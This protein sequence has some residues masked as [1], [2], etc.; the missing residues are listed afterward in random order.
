MFRQLRLLWAV[1]L[2]VL[3]VSVGVAAAAQPPASANLGG[4]GAARPSK[5]TVGSNTSFW[6]FVR[7]FGPSPATGVILSDALPAGV[8]FVSALPDQGSCTGT[9]TVLCSLGS[10]AVNQRVR[11][12]ITVKATAAGSLT[13]QVSVTANEHDPSLSNN[14]FNQPLT[15]LATTA[16]PPPV[17]V[18]NLAHCKRGCK[19]HLTIT[20]FFA[21]NSTT[22]AGS[23]D[24]TVAGTTHGG[25]VVPA[26]VVASQVKNGQTVG[27]LG[28]EPGSYTI[29]EQGTVLTNATSTVLCSGETTPSSLPHTITITKHANVTCTIINT[30]H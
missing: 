30:L 26:T 6:L 16:A 9:T 28:V 11:V 14:S 29:S 20:T 22:P 4:F 23:I 12:L 18:G 27:P 25:L 1:V 21:P 7:D 2:G 10:L 13:N 17:H 3:V 8:S 15:V 24:L 19:Q 5:L